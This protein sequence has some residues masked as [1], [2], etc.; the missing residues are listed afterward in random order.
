VRINSGSTLP[1]TLTNARPG[2]SMWMDPVEN[3]EGAPDMTSATAIVFGSGAM[4]TGRSSGRDC[5]AHSA[6]L[7]YSYRHWKTWLALTPFSR[8]T[9]AIDAPGTSVA[10]TMRRF[11]SAVRRTRFAEPLVAA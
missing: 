5:L 3:D 7:R 4:V 9:R 1:S 10:S 11:S 8:A 6:P 2:S